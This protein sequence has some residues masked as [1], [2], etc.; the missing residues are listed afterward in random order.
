M[1]DKYRQPT[2]SDILWTP[3]NPN[4]PSGSGSGGLSS[5]QDSRL[6]TVSPRYDEVTS[7]AWD[8][9]NAFAFWLASHGPVKGCITEIGVGSRQDADRWAETLH[10]TLQAADSNQYATIPYYLWS[11]RETPS[12]GLAV[13][14]PDPR[15]MRSGP[16]STQWPAGKVMEQHLTDAAGNPRPVGV[17]FEM[18]L[19]GYEYVQYAAT[20]P[21]GPLNDNRKFATDATSVSVL[22][23]FP[24]GSEY[25]YGRFST[26]KYVASRGVKNV[27]LAFQ[28]ER[29]CRSDNPGVIDATELARLDQAIGWAQQFGIKVLLDLHNFGHYTFDNGGQRNDHYIGDGTLTQTHFN[30]FWTALV[31]HYKNGTGASLY[32]AIAGYEIMNEPSNM[33]DFGGGPLTTAQ[34][35]ANW[36]TISNLCVR[37]I[38]AVDST[39]PCYISAY[40]Y[41]SP[42]LFGTLHQ[43]PW[44]T[45]AAGGNDP[46]TVYVAHLYLDTGS[47]GA[48]SN[49][50]DVDQKYWRAQG[51][52]PGDRGAKAQAIATHHIT[53][54]KPW[55]SPWS[56]KMAHRMVKT[57][58]GASSGVA[59][60]VP[61]GRVAI[62]SSVHVYSGPAG[63]AG[64]NKLYF[65]PSGQTPAQNSAWA[66]AEWAS[67]TASTGQFVQTPGV[68]AAGDKIWLYTTVGDQHVAVTVYE[69]P[70][71]SIVP[72]KGA[73]APG[74]DLLLFTCPAG[75]RARLL[76]TGFGVGNGLGMYFRNPNASASIISFRHA[77][78]GAGFTTFHTVSLAAFSN[79][80][81]AN[82][83]EV[84]L[85][86]GE[87]FGINPSVGV[88]VWGAFEVTG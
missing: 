63:G 8:Q 85:L 66:V 69:L 27:R 71:D 50:Y 21:F 38:R 14:S 31:D 20:R 12:N 55:E 32:S 61:F 42:G 39:M 62:I 45:L 23:P 80:A 24:D 52:V 82:V 68:L 5:V 40:N 70:D 75:K 10:G 73:A 37:A 6:N 4:P 76:S 88:N 33:G 15:V 86:D 3:P 77:Y 64:N 29:M 46:N 49:P 43:N 74:S 22:P 34:A 57:D 72:F 16:M 65:V 47:A 19:M 18:G 7:A 36:E 1:G 81:A 17:N 9:I 2:G 53:V 11:C 56:G 28:W 54:P 87:K 25:S 78:S 26:W 35:A 83:F 48:Y 58:I 13:Y 67:T 60:T 30:N 41:A 59:Y 44:V 79:S 84:P 51:Y